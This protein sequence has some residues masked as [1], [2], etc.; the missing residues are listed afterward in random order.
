MSKRYFYIEES[1]YHSGK[2]LI[3]IDFTMLP[4]MHTTGSYNLLPA[5]LLSLSYADYLRYCR[6]IHKAEVIGK[7]SI[8]PVAYFKD[9]VAAGEL[10]QTLNSRMAVIEQLNQRS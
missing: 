6:D 2:Y 1:P 8:Y 9:K 4:Q 5:R 10:V 3:K 7:N